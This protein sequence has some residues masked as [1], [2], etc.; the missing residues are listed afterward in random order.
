MFEKQIERINMLSLDDEFKFDLK[1]GRV[2]NIKGK[3]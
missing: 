1:S 3:I 2:V